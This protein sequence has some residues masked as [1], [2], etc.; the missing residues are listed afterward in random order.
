MGMAAGLDADMAGRSRA[1]LCRLVRRYGGSVSTALLDPSCDL[2]RAQAIEGAIGFRSRFGCAVSIGDPVCA[3]DDKPRLARAFSEHCRARRLHTAYAVAG[4]S[5]AHWAADHG[6]GALCFGEELSFDP[7][8]DP[9]A[10]A[11]GRELRK[12]LFRAG[13]EGIEVIEYRPLRGR[14]PGAEREMEAVARSWLDARS[15]PQVYVVPVRLFAHLEGRRLFYALHRGR[16]VG[17]LSTVRL[18]ARGGYLFDHHLVLPDAPIGTSESLIAEALRTFGG[19]GCGWATFGPAPA[20][21]LGE[22]LGLSQ[23]QARLA[24]SVFRKL[25][26]TFHFESRNR[27]RRKFQVA[28]SQSSYLLVSPP[29]FGPRE[30]GG[31][32][33]AFNASLAWGYSRG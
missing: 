1:S 19:E 16:V 3:E 4:P 24:R 30:I 2:F 23:R 26:Q 5:F 17:V 7:R 18:E 8:R 28:S 20:N 33:N 14:D 12:K 15:G 25:G 10:G 31:L 11:P 21:E 9:A 29:R 22:I 27:Y 32:V 13:R 6:Y